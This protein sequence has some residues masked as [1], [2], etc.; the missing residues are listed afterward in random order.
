MSPTYAFPALPRAS[1]SAALAILYP[2]VGTVLRVPLRR[3]RTGGANGCSQHP[4][5]QFMAW[6]NRMSGARPGFPL[7]IKSILLVTG[8]PLCE[9]CHRALA[10]FLSRYHLASKLRLRTAGA[11]ACGCAGRC[12]CSSRARPAQGRAYS[13]NVLVLDQ[14]ISDSELEEEGWWQ[15]AK[16]LG[17][18]AI[19]AGT[20]M[21]PANGPLKPLHDMVSAAVGAEEQRRK[22]QQTVDD[23]SPRNSRRSG[24]VQKPDDGPRRRPSREFEQAYG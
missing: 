1:T 5:R 18:A 4:E 22:T 12:G 11:S 8:E 2:K 24:Q 23:N 7:Q 16:D 17:K 20:L 19:M 10:T 6:F 21:F 9:S 15:R 14:L 13:A 3:T